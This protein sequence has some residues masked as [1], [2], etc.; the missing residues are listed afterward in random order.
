MDSQF[1]TTTLLECHSVQASELHASS[2]A[3][4][5]SQAKWTSAG[6]VVATKRV[7]AFF[8]ILRG[9]KQRKFLKLKDAVKLISGKC[10]YLENEEI[11]L[12]NVEETLSNCT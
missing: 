5:G 6:R 8:P 2:F 3:V 9:K 12:M 7:P 11:M 1:D 4:H 10:T